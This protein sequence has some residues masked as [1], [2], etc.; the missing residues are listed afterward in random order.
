[1]ASQD[2]D[3]AKK[4]ILTKAEQADFKRFWESDA[5]KKYQDKLKNTKEQLLQAAMGSASRDEVCRY[6]LI[7]NGFESVLQDIEMTIKAKEEEEKPAKKK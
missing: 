3:E 7:A 6:A 4:Y 5:G 2:K 1:M